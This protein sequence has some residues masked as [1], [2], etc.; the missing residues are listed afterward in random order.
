[1]SYILVNDLVHLLEHLSFRLRCSSF[2]LSKF[3]T[4]LKLIQSVVRVGILGVCVTSSIF[5]VLLSGFWVS[6]SQVSSF[7]HPVPGSLVSGSHAPVPESSVSGFRVPGSQSHRFPG[8][9]VPGIKV[10]GLRVLAFRVPGL[11]ILGPG[12][13]ILILDYALYFQ[14]DGD[15]RQG[16]V[17][18]PLFQ[19]YFAIFEQVLVNFWYF[20]PTI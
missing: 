5:R 19:Q 10:P 13:Q 14:Y 8:P 17:H 12:S 4:Q 7:R 18:W 20:I 11:R 2:L 16:K 9:R 15:R 3:A 1:M 6:K